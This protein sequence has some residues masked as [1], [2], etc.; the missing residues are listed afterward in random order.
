MILFA[1]SSSEKKTHKK[2]KFGSLHSHSNLRV[3]KMT[4]IQINGERM[5]DLHEKLLLKSIK[6]HREENV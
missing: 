6:Q 1:G 4:V 5:S 2:Q 3:C